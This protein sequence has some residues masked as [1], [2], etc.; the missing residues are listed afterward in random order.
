[1]KKNILVILIIVGVIGV[2]AY[3]LKDKLKVLLGERAEREEIKE[4]IPGAIMRRP[5]SFFGLMPFQPSEVTMRR[6]IIE[7]VGE[8][9]ARWLQEEIAPLLEPLYP[10]RYI[11]ITKGLLAYLVMGE[12]ALP[13]IEAKAFKTPVTGPYSWALPQF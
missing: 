7:Q 3:L 13:P 5:P 8:S 10:A 11:A 2:V 1:M 9:P 4:P 12:A 6:G